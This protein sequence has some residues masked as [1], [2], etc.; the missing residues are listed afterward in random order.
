MP[1]PTLDPRLVSWVPV[2]FGSDFPVQNLPF[3]VFSTPL[4]GARVGVAIGDQVLDLAEVHAAGHLDVVGLPP[5][6]LAGAVLNPL[7]ECGPD[8]WRALRRRV[9]ELLTSDDALRADPERYLVPADAVALVL[10]VA[11]TDFVDFY[12]SVHHASNVGLMFR[13]DDPPLLPNWRHLPVGYHGRTSTVVVSGTPVVRP[14]G[15]LPGSGSEVPRFGP[16]EKLDFEVEVG[17]V[18]GTANP[19]GATIALEDA[20][21]HVFGMCLVNDW[22]ARDLQ[23]WEYRPLGPFLAKSFAT[24]MSPW[25]VGLDALQPFRVEPPVQ[26]PEP[27][28]YLVDPVGGGAVDITLTVAVNGEVVSRPRYAVMYW[29]MR[30]QLAHA[31][32]NGAAVTPGDLFASGTV[33]GPTRGELGC[34]LELTWNGTDPIEVGGE[35][36]T[37]LEDGDS[38]VIGGRAEAEGAVAIGFGQC[39]GTVAPARDGGAQP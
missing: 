19:I 38:V 37:F 17:F 15:Q 26:D 25:V 32:V 12:S 28:S 23:A 10:P 39:A 24:T 2:G 1:D 20:E 36:R 4:R 8:V 35:R 16:S 29:T 33:S 11:I 22:S 31:T 18:A 6:T 5:G 7:L 3:G 30:Q 27:T 13:P 34:L 21:G 9:S 14:R